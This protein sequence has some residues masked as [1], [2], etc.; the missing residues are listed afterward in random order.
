M[1]W[2]PPAPAPKCA[3]CEKSVYA[4]EE[5]GS[6]GK[7]YHKACFKCTLCKRQLARGGELHHE[8]KP[9]CAKPC[10]A[11]ASGLGGFRA[12]GGA[13]GGGGTGTG[14]GACGEVVGSTST[15]NPADVAIS[16]GVSKMAVAPP[17]AATNQ[18]ANP[19]GAKVAK[20][21]GFKASGTPKCPTCG[22]SVYA[23]EELLSNGNSYHK[24][25]FKCADCKRPLAKGAELMHEGNPYC[26]V[27]CH[28]KA[29]GLVGMRAG[30]GATG[31]GSAGITHGN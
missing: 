28:G 16:T 18:K 27:P 2:T 6:K 17:T 7:S 22:K 8:E 19:F 25:C 30:G 10:H 15:V 26:A 14:H 29:S 5:I 24:G 9:Y 3:L 13:T 23:Q 11:T 4:N 31:S 1:V 20:G 12:G 21:G